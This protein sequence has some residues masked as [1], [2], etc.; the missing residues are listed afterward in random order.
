MATYIHSGAV[1]GDSIAGT[2]QVSIRSILLTAGSGNA[3]ATIYSNGVAMI[4]LN[5]PANDS[6][7]YI[8]VSGGNQFSLETFPGPVTIDV[9]GTGAFVRVSY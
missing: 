7:E 8:S 5:C 2:S 3:T 9:A 6:K 1:T 4:V